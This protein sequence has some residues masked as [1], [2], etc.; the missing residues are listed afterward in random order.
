MPLPQAR[1]A[2]RPLLA[3]VILALSTYRLSV[4]DLGISFD[5]AG[6]RQVSSF[7]FIPL[8]AIRA[9][10]VGPQ[11]QD[12]PRAW[13]R[14]GWWPGRRRVNVLHAGEDG[15]LRAFHVWVTDPGAFGMAVLGRAMSDLD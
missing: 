1:L 15:A 9:A 3:A 6:L 14:G 10:R 2:W 13:V 4:G 7:G 12:W 5:I 8:Y 11:P